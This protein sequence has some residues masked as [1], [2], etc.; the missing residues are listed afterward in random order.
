[1]YEVNT[2]ISYVRWFHDKEIVEVSFNGKRDA[3]MS[4]K[5]AILQCLYQQNTKRKLQDAV[6]ED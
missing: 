5:F 2:D 3:A 4:L 6:A 1:M